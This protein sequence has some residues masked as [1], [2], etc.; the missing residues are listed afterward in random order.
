MLV[1]VACLCYQEYNGI[2]AGY[3]FGAP[4]PLGYGAGLLLLAPL[5]EGW[6]VVTGVAVLL[7]AWA[8]RAQDLGDRGQ[9]WS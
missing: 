2:A 8:M 9:P 4:G 3:G 5:P 1:A 6:F 7:L